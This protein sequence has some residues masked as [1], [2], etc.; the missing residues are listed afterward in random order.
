MKETDPLISVYK[1][2]MN[3]QKA[4]FALI[5]HEDTMVATVFKV[6]QP[7]GEEFILKICSRAGD[8]FRE[9][10]FFESFSWEDSDSPHY[11]ADFSKG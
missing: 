10:S 8:Y 7:N 4:H 2:R 1:G 5:D 11:S 3:F 9:A 6:T